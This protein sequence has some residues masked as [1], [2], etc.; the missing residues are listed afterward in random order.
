[1]NGREKWHQDA[2]VYQVYLPSFADGDGDGTGDL[3][4]VTSRL[5]YIKDL[6]V[7]GI[8]LSPF[9]PSGGEDGGYDVVS[10]TSVDSR[11]GSLRDFDELVASCHKFGM[12]VLLD[13]VPNHCSSQHPWFVQALKAGPGSPERQRFHFRRGRGPSANEPPNNWGSA[14]GGP[15]WTRASHDE[16]DQE[17]YLHMFGSGQPDLNWESPEVLSAF[18]DVLLFWLRRGVDG[19]RIDVAEGLS[20]HPDYPDWQAAAGIG[21]HNPYLAGRPEGRAVISRWRDLVERANPDAMLIGEI[22]GE[23]PSYLTP[24]VDGTGLDYV[25][26]FNLMVQP[27]DAASMRASLEGAFEVLSTSTAGLAWTLG[28]HDVRRVVSRYGRTDAAQMEAGI[29]GLIQRAQSDGPTDTALGQM[30]ARAAFLLVAFLPG[31]CFIY[32]GDELGLPDVT[33]LPDSARRDPQYVRSGGTVTGRDGCRVPLP[34]TR[35]GPGL[36]FSPLG[37]QHSPWLPQPSWFEQY[38]AE[39]QEG[40]PASTLGLYRRALSIRRTLTH[41]EPQVSDVGN[42]DLLVIS[43]GDTA[44]ILNSGNGAVS[45]PPHTKVLLAS[46]AIIDDRLPARAACWV[47]TR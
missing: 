43:R 44:C 9:Y 34:W 38:S 35:S 5:R 6:G 42:G 15:A 8:W 17:W 46:A 28:N 29:P 39:S 3:R 11:Y 4:G 37:S 47:T 23:R 2:V 30:R 27:F 20:K 40:D 24:Y 22:W 33:D 21:G 16:R 26:Y 13:L 31:E 36:G 45:L 1:M 12:R 7:D 25:F 41:A 18:D 10:Y 32:Q 14:F 19:F